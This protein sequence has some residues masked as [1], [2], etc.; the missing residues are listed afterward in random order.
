MARNGLAA[1]TDDP[2]D[3]VQTVRL[4]LRSDRH[5]ASD[6]RTV[7]QRLYDELV[8]TH[9][10]LLR[11]YDILR[12]D[13]E[14]ELLIAHALAWAIV[15]SSEVAHEK[16]FAYLSSIATTSGDRDMSSAYRRASERVRE[17][18]ALQKECW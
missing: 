18:S 15:S 12:K 17:L 1:A 13:W 7:E 6:D 4:P 5:L 9:D 10:Q 2:E 16:A 8:E 11:E 14:R 3:N